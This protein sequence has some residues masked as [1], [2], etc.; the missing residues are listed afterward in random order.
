MAWILDFAYIIHFLY[1]VIFRENSRK[2]QLVYCSSEKVQKNFWWYFNNILNVVEPKT[3]ENVGS[4]DIL[5]WGLPGAQSEWTFKVCIKNIWKSSSLLKT[6]RCVQ[7]VYIHQVIWL[8]SVTLESEVFRQHVIFHENIRF[9]HSSRVHS[10][11]ICKLFWKLYHIGLHP[12]QFCIFEVDIL[13]LPARTVG[14]QD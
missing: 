5:L 13:V 14:V 6:A 12:W 1:W 3:I 11:Y 8:H 9:K 2:Y 10:K 4:E 7:K